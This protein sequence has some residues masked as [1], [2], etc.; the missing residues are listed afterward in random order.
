MIV[1]AIIAMLSTMAIPAYQRL[2][3]RSRATLVKQ[4]LRNIDDALSIYAFERNQTSGAAV[5]FQ[6]IRGYLKENTGLYATGLD[7]LG[8][9]YGPQFTVGVCP[10]P[11]LATYQQLSD[12]TDEAF[13][14]PYGAP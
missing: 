14:S 3:K 5:G 4:D 6:D 7:I 2:M 1:V 13:W 11:P 9:P 10:K 8:N 12:V